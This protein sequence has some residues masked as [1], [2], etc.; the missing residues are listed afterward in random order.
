VKIHKQVGDVY[1]YIMYCIN[2]TKWCC[3]LCEGRDDVHNEQRSGRPSLISVDLLQ[4]TEAETRINQ[5]RTI[6]ELHHITPKPSKTT[7]NEGVTEKLQYRKLC[8]LWVP[9]M[10][11]VDHKT[12]QKCTVLKFLTC[13][14]EEG[15]EFLDSIVIGD[16]TWALS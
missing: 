11:T 13:H 9:K 8:T 7:I 16:E 6:R 1:D 14:A 5:H 2:V 15:D 12:K 3:K 4:K 10:L